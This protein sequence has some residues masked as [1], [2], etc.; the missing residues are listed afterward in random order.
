MDELKRLL[1]SSPRARRDRVHRDRAGLGEELLVVPPARFL[2]ELR[3]LCDETGI[4]LVADEIQSGIGR[5][6]KFFAVEHFGIVPDVMTIAKGIASGLPLSGVITRQE[7]DR[8]VSTGTHSRPAA[9]STVACTAGVATVRAIK[10]NLLANA[11][12][13]GAVDRRPAQAPL[14]CPSLAM[15]AGWG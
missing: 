6:G 14:N 8:G 10:K 1:K 5:T 12:R 7:Y 3:A 9:G 13:G 2:R 4:L 15:C 11:P